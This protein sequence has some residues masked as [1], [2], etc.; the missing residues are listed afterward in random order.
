MAAPLR[1]RPEVL[2]LEASVDRLFQRFD[3]LDIDQTEI[4]AD[5]ANYLCVSVVGLLERSLAVLVVEV[6]RTRAA[7]E[8][9]RLVEA[10]VERYTTNPNQERLLQL[11][12][13]LSI[14][15]RNQLEVFLDDAG[16]GDA[17]NSL[18]GLRNRIAHGDTSTGLTYVRVS[19]YYDRVKDV[20][21]YVSELLLPTNQ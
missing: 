21:E 4:R 6:A 5:F 17:L 18:Y 20:L 11:M 7:P 15:W 13:R 12:G 9:V 8:V 14:T 10:T 3:D 1:G 16:R 2:R 19:G